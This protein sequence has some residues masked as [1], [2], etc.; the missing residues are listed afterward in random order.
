[1]KNLSL[2]RSEDIPPLFQYEK[3]FCNTSSGTNLKEAGL[4]FQKSLCFVHS[5]I[6]IS[7]ACQ[8]YQIYLLS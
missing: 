6:K 3:I 8:L 5:S 7:E 2:F 4:L 1:M